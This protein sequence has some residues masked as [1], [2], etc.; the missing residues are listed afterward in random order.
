[1]NLG[2]SYIMSEILRIYTESLRKFEESKLV[3]EERY[4]LDEI[5]EQVK[6]PIGDFCDMYKELTFIYIRYTGTAEYYKDIDPFRPIDNEPDQISILLNRL[7]S[8]L[9]QYI[10]AL[11][12]DSIKKSDL[13]L[14]SLLKYNTLFN[15]SLIQ[16]IKFSNILSE[17]NSA[18]IDF[19]T[20]LIEF[21]EYITYLKQII[22]LKIFSEEDLD[23]VVC[24]CIQFGFCNCN[25]KNNEKIFQALIEILR[26][27]SDDVKVYG[28]SL[29]LNGIL[30]YKLFLNCSSISFVF[31]KQVKEAIFRVYTDKIADFDT[32]LSEI[33]NNVK[34]QQIYTRDCQTFISNLATI[35]NLFIVIQFTPWYNIEP[36]ISESILKTHNAYQQVNFYFHSLS[37]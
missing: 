17:P 6:R 14:K 4:V 5:E 34:H 23:F 26:K 9:A 2:I 32:D 3:I 35:H 28:N 29:N 24:V 16:T 10:S 7:C 22:R 30:I 1:M 12:S 21:A 25:E 8:K 36:S 27:Y 19:F 11:Y 31:L 33:L 20:S 15:S 13:S 18:P 37:Q